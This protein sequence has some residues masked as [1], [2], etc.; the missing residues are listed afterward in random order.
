M[1]LIRRRLI[2]DETTRP[3]THTLLTNYQTI[4]TE[5]TSQRTEMNQEKEGERKG[6]RELRLVTRALI[7]GNW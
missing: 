3:H 2:K 7:A 1:C 4:E 5:K 6:E